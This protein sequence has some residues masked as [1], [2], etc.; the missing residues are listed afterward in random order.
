MINTAYIIDKNKPYEE[1]GYIVFSDWNVTKHKL[2]YDNIVGNRPAL[3]SWR[4][5]G[6]DIVE[7]DICNYDARKQH[8][9]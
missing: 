8:K 3:C 9:C 1:K 6:R 5:E 2:V 7:I 4:G